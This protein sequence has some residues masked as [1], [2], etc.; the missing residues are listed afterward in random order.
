MQTENNKDEISKEIANLY[1]ENKLY[2]FLKGKFLY[3]LLFCLFI[4]ALIS[5]IVI[6]DGYIALI[7]ILSICAIFI[8]VLIVQRVM[9][10]KIIY[11][12]NKKVTGIKLKPIRQVWDCVVFIIFD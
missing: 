10:W 5:L 12:T 6:N 8:V 4:S 2:N 7:T 11:D 9:I 1:E 3:I